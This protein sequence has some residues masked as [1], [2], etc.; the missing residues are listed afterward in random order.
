MKEKKKK[1]KEE[2]RFVDS[3]WR[4]LFV[5]LFKE[6]DNKTPSHLSRIY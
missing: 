4:L 5:F 1:K 6:S 3:F 2:A